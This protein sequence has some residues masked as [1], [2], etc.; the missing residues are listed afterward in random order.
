MIT[1][2]TLTYERSLVLLETLSLEY[3]S[4]NKNYLAINICNSLDVLSTGLMWQPEA[5][6]GHEIYGCV[7][8][9]SVAPFTNM[10]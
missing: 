4:N 3:K 5:F 2:K 1:W 8:F 10:D 7:I 6:I 9:M